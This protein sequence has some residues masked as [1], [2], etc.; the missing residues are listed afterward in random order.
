LRF[1]G[2]RF[3][4]ELKVKKLFGIKEERMKKARTKKKRRKRKKKSKEE[5][6]R[7][8]RILIRSLFGFYY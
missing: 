1:I 3:S 2:Q 4:K 8:T 7:E 6:V 5:L